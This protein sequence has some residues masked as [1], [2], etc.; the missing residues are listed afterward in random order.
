MEKYQQSLKKNKGVFSPTHTLL[1]N[2]LCA[3]V[4]FGEKGLCK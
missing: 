2:L 3:E 1:L 4:V